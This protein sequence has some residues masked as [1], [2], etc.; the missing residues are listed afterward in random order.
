MPAKHWPSLTSTTSVMSFYWCQETLDS[1]RRRGYTGEPSICAKQMV[2]SQRQPR[3]LFV[4]EDL[5]ASF[6][7]NTL[8]SFQ[9]DLQVIS[10]RFSQNGFDLFMKGKLNSLAMQNGISPRKS[11]EEESVS[12]TLMKAHSWQNELLFSVGWGHMHD[13]TRTLTQHSF[14]FTHLHTL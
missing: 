11:D 6:F 10:N 3:P 8:S 14:T 4:L 13:L 12:A 9:A 7:S 1:C 2:S 5:A